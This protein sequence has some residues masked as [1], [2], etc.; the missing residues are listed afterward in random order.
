MMA[1]NS[2]VVVASEVDVEMIMLMLMLSLVWMKVRS[3]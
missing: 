1:I 3:M 2:F